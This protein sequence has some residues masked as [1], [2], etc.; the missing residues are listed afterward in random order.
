M[1]H[2]VRL[3][4]REPDE[5]GTVPDG[6]RDDDCSDLFGEEAVGEAPD[7]AGDH[8]SHD[9]HEIELGHMYKSVYESRQDESYIR[10]PACRKTVLDA[11][12]PEDFLCR[13]DDQ[14][15]EQS[16]HPWIFSFLHSVDVVDLRTCEVEPCGRKVLSQPEN[17]PKNGGKGNSDED[18]VQVYTDILPPSRTCPACE[19]G[20]CGSGTCHHY[21]EVDMGSC[22]WGEHYGPKNGRQAYADGRFLQ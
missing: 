11:S 8:G 22:P 4:D 10:V 19:E 12:A 6:V 13:A 5:D 21:P 16:K 1:A 14:K 15:H 9:E 20:Q 18:V 7:E 2:L 17:A 3:H